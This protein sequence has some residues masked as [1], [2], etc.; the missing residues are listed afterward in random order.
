[1]LS[2]IVPTK[3]RDDEPDS[4]CKHTI[5]REGLSFNLVDTEEPCLSFK[6]LSVLLQDKTRSEIN[7]TAIIVKYFFIPS[8]LSFFIKYKQK[9]KN[10]VPNVINQ[11]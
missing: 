9:H 4:S 6:L 8:N 2:K 7:I 10:H 3:F 11:K 5:C 1:L